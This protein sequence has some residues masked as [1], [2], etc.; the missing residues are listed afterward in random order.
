M[1]AALKSTAKFKNRDVFKAGCSMNP[2]LWKNT[3]DH[4]GVVPQWLLSRSGQ[5]IWAS[6]TTLGGVP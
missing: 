1:A 2:V 4:G 5:N 6:R 3:N